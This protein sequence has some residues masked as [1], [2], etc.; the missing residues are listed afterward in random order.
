M[1]ESK[2]ENTDKDIINFFL[3]FVFMI[4]TDLLER[5]VKNI[6]SQSNNNM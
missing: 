5:R 2:I 6:F 3:C 4:I 1:K